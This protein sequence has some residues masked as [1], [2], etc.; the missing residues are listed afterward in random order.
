MC[1]YAASSIERTGVKTVHVYQLNFVDHPTVDERLVYICT[2]DIQSMKK[3]DQ[4]TNNIF[5]IFIL[6]NMKRSLLR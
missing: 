3:I 6:L 1:V 2:L 5:L 4:Q